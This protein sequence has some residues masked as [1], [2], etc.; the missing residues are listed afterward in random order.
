MRLT[1]T[2][3]EVSVRDDH[4]SIEGHS[5]VCVEVEDREDDARLCEDGRRYPIP[6]WRSIDARVD[7][8]EWML[9]DGQELL[10]KYHHCLEMKYHFAGNVPSYEN[11]SIL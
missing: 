2:H 3:P 7:G 10:T 11:R 9:C 5:Q 4:T 1:A 8:K 6:A